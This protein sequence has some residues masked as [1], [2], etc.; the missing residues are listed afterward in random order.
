M[1]GVGIDADSA[2]DS[3]ARR[4]ASWRSNRKN[5]REP[6][7]QEL[8]IA[9]AEL[10]KT[11]PIAHVCRRLGLCSADLKKHLEKE[12]SFVELDATH[13]GFGH[14]QLTCERPDGTTLKLSG[15]GIPFQIETLLRQFLT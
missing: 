7:P 13:L 2:I 6:I 4:F 9:A 12:V 5:R 14:W 10:C 3:V 1:S 8:W 15:S 11:H